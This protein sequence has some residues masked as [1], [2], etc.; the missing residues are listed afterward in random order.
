MALL[1]HFAAD[2]VDRGVLGLGQHGVGHVL[3]EHRKQILQRRIDRTFLEFLFIHKAFGVEKVRIDKTREEHPNPEGHIRS[4]GRTALRWGC[5]Q[6]GIWDVGLES[7]RQQV[8][9]LFK[10]LAQPSM[11]LV[12]VPVR[13][14]GVVSGNAVGQHLSHLSQLFKGMECPGS[15]VVYPVG[16]P[17]EMSLR[18][19]AAFSANSP[20]ESI[21]VFS[22]VVPESGEKR[23]VPAAETFCM[24]LCP[25]RG[26]PQVGFQQVQV[27]FREVLVFTGTDMGEGK[28][29][30][31]VHVTSSQGGQL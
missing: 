26:V 22:E 1:Q 8:L 13:Q 28:R 20:L 6:N 15:G 19:I 18:V 4:L 11:R 24:A 21:M 27:V 2:A 12:A 31:S 29:V 25:T 14:S 9:L 30:G 5:F 16:L 10:P 7:F 23:P 3:L 17:F